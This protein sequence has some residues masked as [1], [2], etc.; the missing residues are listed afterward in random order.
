M[1]EEEKTENEKQ[2]MLKKLR[3]MEIEIQEEKQKKD[4]YNKTHYSNHKEMIAEMSE[5]EKAEYEQK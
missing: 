5:E 4:S 2:K 1:S 3:K